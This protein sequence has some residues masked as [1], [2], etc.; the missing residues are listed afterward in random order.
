[1]TP[2]TICG[3]SWN[4]AASG[5]YYNVISNRSYVLADGAVES[6]LV[7]NNDA[8]TDRKIIHIMEIDPKSEDIQ[9]LPGYYGIDKLNPD[10]L[11]DDT[12]WTSAVLPDT[13]SYYEDELGYNVIGAMNTAL[14]DQSVAPYGYMVYEGIQLGAPWINPNSVTYMAVDWE[15]NIDLRDV[16]DPLTGDERTVI[17]VNFSFIV[18][19]GVNVLDVDDPDRTASRCMIG[20]KADG[21]LV[22]CNVDGRSAPISNGLTVRQMGELMIS[23][24]CVHALHCDGGGSATFMTKREGEAENTVRSIASDG[25]L[26]PVINSIIIAKRTKGDGVFTHASLTVHADS[27]APNGSVTVMAHGLD[28]ANDFAPLPAEGLT[29]SL[30]DDS[31]GTVSEGVF[32]SNGKEGSVAV[33]LMWNGSVVGEVTVHV[34]EPPIAHD[35]AVT[36]T[37]LVCRDCGEVARGSGPAYGRTDTFFLLDGRPVT[38]W[39]GDADGWF[40]LK[41]DYKAAKGGYTVNGIRF[42]FDADTGRLTEGVW[43]KTSTYTRYYYGPSYYKQSWA[44]IDGE[45]YYFGADGNMYTGI[46]LIKGS[47]YSQALWYRFAEDGR[48]LHEGAYPYTGLIEYKGDT[49][50]CKEGVTQFGLWCVEGQYYYFRTGDGLERVGYAVKGT[51]YYVSDTNG[52]TWP[53]GAPVNVGMY[54]FDAAGRLEIPKPKNGPQTDGTFYV[55]DVQQKAYQLVAY[56]GA[57]YFI[58]DR[59]RYIVNKTQYLSTDR[60]RSVGLDLPAGNYRFDAEGKLVAELPTLKNGPQSDGFFYVNDVKQAAYKL[61]TY[62]GAYYFIGDYNKYIV[63]KTQYLSTDRLRSVG[64]DL[65]AG[66]YRFDAEGKL[67]A[68]L[69]T[70]KNGPQSDGFFYANDVKQA[71]YK[72]VEYNGDYYFIGDYNRYITNKTHYLTAARLAAVG[73]DLPAGYYQFDAQGRLVW[74]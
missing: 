40:Y 55:N 46:R 60:L 62:K 1:M 15:G 66:N 67:V 43:V 63:N 9:I 21:T 42:S 32:T 10:D 4:S 27:C 20:V 16:T 26:R 64:L 68:E 17:P 19:D 30:S 37:S 73:L 69:P 41:S 65:P 61:V 45:R 36:G 11:K 49:Y 14:N 50:Y 57:Y 29:W 59:N 31:F 47:A 44:E 51:Q 56:E 74:D 52:L 58:G 8:G 33:R 23:L 38:G 53:S 22:I 18:R 24:G 5:G 28:F 2:L 48:I 13:V 12:Y 3:V 54:T 25:V 70:L 35:Y 72:L 71:A 34:E 39:H 7:V 6:E